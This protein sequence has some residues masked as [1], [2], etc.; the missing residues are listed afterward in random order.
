MYKNVQLSEKINFE[1]QLCKNCIQNNYVNDFLKHFK[2]MN[3]DL[4]FGLVKV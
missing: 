4:L 3:G 2:D 1:K